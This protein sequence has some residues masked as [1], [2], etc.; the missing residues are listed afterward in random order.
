MDEFEKFDTKTFVGRLLGRGDWRGFVEK[1][2]VSCSAAESAGL[3][4]LDPF[5][6]WAYAISKASFA[7][8]MVML[9]SWLLLN[10]LCR[11]EAQVMILTGP[12]ICQCTWRH[13]CRAL[14]LIVLRRQFA[15]QLTLLGQMV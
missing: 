15:K 11:S 2:Q 13:Q 4:L 3:I 8:L 9:A 1:I 14:L 12:S 6:S 7:P 10:T 5:A